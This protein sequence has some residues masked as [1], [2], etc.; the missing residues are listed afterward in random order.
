MYREDT[1]KRI[2][3]ALE[4]VLAQDGTLPILADSN[5]NELAENV[6]VLAKIIS[7]QLWSEGYELQAQCRP[8]GVVAR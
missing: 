6:A 3:R 2:Q 1:R 4:Q 5:P 7:D 8:W